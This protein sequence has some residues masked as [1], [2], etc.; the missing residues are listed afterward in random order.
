M[1]LDSASIEHIV[2]EVVSRLQSEGGR[3]APKVPMDVSGGNGVF[4]DMDD[5]IA[6]ATVA[7]RELVALSLEDRERIV[8]AMRQCTLDQLDALAREAVQ[9]TGLGRVD[10]KI[11]KNRL[12]ATKTPGTEILTPWVRTGDHGLTL[13]ERAPYGVIGAITPC[14]NPTET[15]LCNGLGFVAAGN[16]AVF[17]VHPAAKRLSARFIADLNRAIVGAGGPRNLLACIAEPTIESAGQL[18]THSGIRLVVVTGGGAVVRAAMTSG[19]RCIAGGPGNPPVV[20][21]ETADLDAAARGIIA[22]ASFDN[23]IICTDEKEVL[24]VESIADQLRDKMVATGQAFLV[25]GDALR[26]LEQ[27]IIT[28]DHHVNRE[29]IGKDAAFILDAIGVRA[30]AQT[31][32]IIAD[33]DESHPFVQH[34]LLT[35]IV[36]IVRYPDVQ[37]AIDGAV[38]CEHGYGHTASM[39]SRNLDHLH[40]MARVCN[41]SIYI[42]NASNFA[43]LG[44]GGEGHTSFTIASPTGEGLTTALSFSRIRRCTLKDRFRIV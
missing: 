35:P 43:G 5:A 42:K 39:W 18:M 37:A 38:R 7:Q 4:S 32:L 17:N 40:A 13:E 44:H 9:E 30:P 29:Y 6:A 16:S 28:P 1:S 41:T 3:S 12:V 26:R 31:R 22:G 25:K 10:D 20:V 14:T 11:Q 27:L 15:I 36:G 21:D 34:E 23:N 2:N 24:A 19:K 8:A 33:T